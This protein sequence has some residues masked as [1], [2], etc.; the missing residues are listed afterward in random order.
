MAPWKSWDLNRLAFHPDLVDLAERFLGS[1]DLHLY[2]TELW[3]KYAGAVDYVQVHHRDFVN[4]SLAVSD[5][6]DP[7]RQME[8][9]VLLSDVDEQDGPTKLVHSRLARR[10]RTGR[11]AVTKTSRRNWHR[12]R[13]VRRGRGERDRACR[14]PLHV[15]H[16]RAPPRFADH[17]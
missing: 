1:A 16:R 17:R 8:S 14:H 10:V 2:N 7:G 15:P 11:R 6:G 9:F 13:R 12:A 4:H 3:A 5:R